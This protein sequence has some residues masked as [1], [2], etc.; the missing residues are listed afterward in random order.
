MEI[1]GPVVYWISRFA[2]TPARIGSWRLTAP[3][4][5]SSVNVVFEGISGQKA[6][7]KFFG[8]GMS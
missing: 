5:V 2:S 3:S 1:N 8:S 7:R 4:R 6:V